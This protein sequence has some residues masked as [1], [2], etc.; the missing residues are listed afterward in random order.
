MKTDLICVGTEY[1]IGMLEETDSF[2]LAGR[3][4]ELDLELMRRTVI[5]SAPECVSTEVK[6]SFQNADL[7]LVIGSQGYGKDLRTNQLF[8]E[9]FDTKLSFSDI[10]FTHMKAYVD[11]HQIRVSEEEIRELA[12]LPENAELL[13]N[14]EGLA[15]GYI[16]EKDAKYLVVLPGAS[17][18]IRSVFEDDVVGFIYKTVSL[19]QAAYEL[20][21]KGTEKEEL[22]SLKEISEKL[23]DIIEAENPEISLMRDGE[24]VIL[25][26]HAV[27]PTDG[28]AKVIA[29]IT[30]SNCCSRIG[31]ELVSSIK[32][33]Q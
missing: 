15:C 26:V 18:E 9:L 6:N 23:A 24:E 8:A 5:G 7:V 3:L 20:R 14:H 21:L 33:V 22:P 30:I 32:E 11:E 2:Y 4:A 10:A 25:R 19:G 16:L 31:G 12:N 1:L 13:L 28:D 27:G 17:K 29:Q